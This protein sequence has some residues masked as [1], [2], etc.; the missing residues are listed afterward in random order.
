MPASTGVEWLKPVSRAPVL[1]E[2]IDNVEDP[3]TCA[4]DGLG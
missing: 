4:E 3:V 1:K 2:P